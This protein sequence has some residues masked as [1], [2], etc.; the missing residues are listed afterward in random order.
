MINKN[1]YKAFYTLLYIVTVSLLMVA[2]DVHA[3]DLNFNVTRLSAKDGL[4]CN[5]ING[6]QQDRD[7]FI[8]LSTP[9][10]MSRYDGYQFQNFSKF[11][12]NAKQRNYSSISQLISDNTHGQIWGF[13][14]NNI[15]SLLRSG[16]GTLLRLFRPGCHHYPSGQPIPEFKGNLDFICRLRCTIHLRERRK[17]AKH[18]LYP[19]KRKI[20]GYS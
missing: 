19:A 12:N 17:D 4:S 1:N 20:A 16:G 9:N 14:P 15:L 3:Y 13:T 6:V 10:G 5:T 8:W 2:I 18:R 7:G 11:N